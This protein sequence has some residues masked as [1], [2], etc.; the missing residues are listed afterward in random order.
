MS[1]YAFVL[2]RKRMLSIAEICNV[3]DHTVSIV[4]ITHEALIAE[5]P[6]PL[7]NPQK[8][9]GYLGGIVKIIEIFSE[10]G[11]NMN[12][13]IENINDYLFKKFNNRSSKINYGISLYSFT[14]KHEEILKNIL[15]KTKK[16]LT[17][18]GIKSRF[19]NKNFQN[20]ANAAINGENLL[21]DGA[22]IIV[23]KGNNEL[24]IGETVALQDFESYSKRDYGRPARDPRLG[25]LPPKLAQIM[26]N[27]AGHTRIESNISTTEQGETEDVNSAAVSHPTLYDPFCG[28]G[29][30]LSEGLLLGYNVVG[31]DLSQDALQKAQKN[32]Q[33]IHQQY[34]SIKTK[35]RVFQ[36]DAALIN[37]KDLP[38]KIDFI[39]TESYLGPPL[40]KFPPPEL[41]EKNFAY[42]RRLILAFF[43]A[44][45]TILKSGAVVIISLPAYK[46]MDRLFFMDGIT[47]DIEKLGFK[48]VNL[49]PKSIS[50]Q[51]NLKASS[52]ESLVYD[53]PDQIVA[54]E[55]WKFVK[56]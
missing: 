15:K 43:K 46:R 4:E 35:D 6:K 33:W 32:I 11:Q 42:V 47:T 56:K 36:R 24:L 48:S 18:K 40:S 12:Q 8:S 14:H 29:T 54:R 27:L 28:I 2:G 20:L 22:E 31:S 17:K 49:I 34:P 41:M 23:I 39:V 26:I 25:M 45:N 30:I 7:L 13:I 19:I 21:V 5:F 10:T 16:Y 3:I 9:L 55:I 38:E 1:K 50:K 44:I 37:S 51:F 52:K 53:R